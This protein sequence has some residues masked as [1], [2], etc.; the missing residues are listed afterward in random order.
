MQDIMVEASRLV[1]GVP[2]LVCRVDVNYVRWPDRYMSES[3]SDM[4]QR[5]MKLLASVERKAA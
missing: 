3:G 1:L 2:D 4:W 5:I